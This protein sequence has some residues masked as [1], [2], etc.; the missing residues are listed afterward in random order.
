MKWDGFPSQSA[1]GFFL[2]IAR[3][4][5]WKACAVKHAL[6]TGH[7]VQRGAL[8]L[9]KR[10]AISSNAQLTSLALELST[11]RPARAFR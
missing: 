10:A 6:A 1:E 2:R 5:G 9:Q 4:L 8:G 7:S 3:F 11:I